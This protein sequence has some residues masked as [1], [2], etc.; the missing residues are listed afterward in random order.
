MYSHWRV[1]TEEKLLLHAVRR[2][3]P[4]NIFGANGET[5]PFLRYYILS[6]KIAL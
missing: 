3:F 6:L 5:D 1:E 2:F 4:H